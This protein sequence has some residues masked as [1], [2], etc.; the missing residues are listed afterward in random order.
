MASVADRAALAAAVSFL[1]TGWLLGNADP[2]E[3][4]AAATA[5]TEPSAVVAPAPTAPATTADNRSTPA[6]AATP[7][8]TESETAEP[9]L[10][11]RGNATRTAYGTGP[12]GPAAHVEWAY[13]DRDLCAESTVGEETKTWC[14]TGWTGQP[15]VFT[16][17]G[18]TW[19][20]VGTYDRGIH[21]IDGHT[22]RAILPPFM[23]GDIIKGSVTVDPDGY[24]IVY[25]GSRDGRYR[26]IAFDGESP[27]ELFAITAADA[28][29]P[30]MWN[31][32]WDGA[33]LVVDD[34]L[35]VGGE[36]S[37]LFVARLDRGYDQDGAVTLQAQVIAD[38]AGWDE[39]LLADVGD[40]NM[41]IEGSVAIH[42]GTV[43]FANSGGLVQGWALDSLIGGG[44]PRR[45]FRWWLGDDADA[46]VVIDE[47]TGHLI[48]AAEWERH[49]A[50][51]RE[52]GQVVRLDPSDPEDPMVWGA[53]DPQALSGVDVAGVWATPA[54]WQNLVVVP[55]TSGRLLGLDAGSGVTRWTVDLGDHLWSSPVIVDD[56]LLQGDCAGTLH[57]FDL[58]GVA[59]PRPR[60]TVSLGG[61]C[62]ES[63][64]AVWDGRLYVGTRAGRIIGV[65]LQ[66]GPPSG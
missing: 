11:F 47:V 16:R 3:V 55:T 1:V 12:I 58:E 10:T 9:L 13:P 29:G 30:T 14:G 51:S 42:D 5:A 39:Q 15:A 33:G 49:T 60:W 54:L 32:D 46:S 19:V 45:T 38:V 65:D 7:A 53:H 35:V 44:E 43:Y 8:P 17:D 50:R 66:G 57:A 18:R 62:I 4:A 6:P 48:V 61:G 40:R 59:Q 24:P 23:T 26:A 64:P 22:G 34:H 31:D 20:V 36:N 37:R 25:S 2:A 21:F 52:V 28:T 27:R 41:S 56:V 63:T